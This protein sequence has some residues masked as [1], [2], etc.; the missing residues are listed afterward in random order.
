MPA[1]LLPHEAVRQL[2][3]QHAGQL[4]RHSAQ[5]LHRHAYASVVQRAYP[6]RR[7]RNV[8]KRLLRIEHHADGIRRRKI[9]LGLDRGKMRLQRAQNIAR[10]SRLRRAAVA[11]RKVAAFVFLVTFFFLLVA[12][13]LVERRLHFRIGPQRQRTFPFRDS[14]I[15]FVQCRS[16]PSPPAS[17]RRRFPAQRAARAPD[18]PTTACTR[19]AANAGRPHS[20]IAPALPAHT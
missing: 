13:R 11:Q 6:S 15:D 17:P 18:N 9:Q 12:L 16:M 4:R 14:L 2:V 10:Q 8:R 3:L 5:S 19:S 1:R 20:S 7:S